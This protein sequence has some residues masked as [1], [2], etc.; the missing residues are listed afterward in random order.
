MIFKAFNVLDQDHVDYFKNGG[1]HGAVYISSGTRGIVAHAK[2]DSVMGMI[3]FD[4][5]T[6]NAVFGHIVVTNLMCLKHGGLVTEAMDFVFNTCAL[7]YLMGAVPAHKTKAIEFEKKIGFKEVYRLKDGFEEDI[8]LIFMQMTR[9]TAVFL[10]QE[11][12]A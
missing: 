6:H 5:W 10:P 1:L 7:Q 12:A 11:R 3:L 4:N 2:D 9:D 8:D